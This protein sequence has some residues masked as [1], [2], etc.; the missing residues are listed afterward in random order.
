MH[1]KNDGLSLPGKV[2]AYLTEAQGRIFLRRARLR[3]VVTTI[4]IEGEFANFLE[5]RQ[6]STLT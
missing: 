6:G 5:C 2:K 4:I 3:V 1:E